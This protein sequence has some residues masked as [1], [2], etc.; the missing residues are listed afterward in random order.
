MAQSQNTI[1]DYVVAN[2]GLATETTLSTFTAS[3]DP[4]EIGVF[5]KDGTA[6]T[7]GKPFVVALKTD[8]SIIVSD[9]I[10]PKRVNNVYLQ[11]YAAEVPR[12]VTLSTFPVPANAGERYEYQ[13]MIRI[14]RFGSHSNENF[15]IKHGH[16]ILTQTSGPLTAQAVVDGLID[17]LNKSFSKEPK[18]T[19]TTNPLFTFARTSSGA[20]SNLVITA[21]EQPLELGKREGRPIDFNVTVQVWKVGDEMFGVPQPTVTVTQAGHPGTGTGKRV[22]I[23]EF[24][25]R[26]ARGDANKGVGYPY[27]WSQA[28][29]TLADQSATY[30][31][32]HLEHDIAGDGFNALIM[33]KTVTVACKIGDTDAEDVLA[34]IQVF[35]EA[36]EPEE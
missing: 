17:N 23:N 3:A 32:V 27:T 20:G 33:P 5:S 25:Y 24:F 31:L 22:A 19:A 26:G 4:G 29:K 35:L 2:E 36:P 12:Q 16:F 21:K 11:P 14:D 7:L 15:Y 28:T 1:R 8:D 18:A 6:P 30:D 13:V 34:A 9:V 10:K